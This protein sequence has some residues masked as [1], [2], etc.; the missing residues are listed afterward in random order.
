MVPSDRFEGH[1]SG[2]APEYEA[3]LADA[4]GL[5]L[6]VVFDTLGPTER[7]AVVLHD[8]FAMPFG[9]LAPIVGRSSTAARQ[10]ASRARRRVQRATTDADADRTGQRAV[11]DAFL[12]AS[13]VGDFET[14]VALLDPDVVLRADRT[15]VQT[16]ASAEVRGAL[17]VAGQFSGRARDAQPALVNGAAGAMWAPG[18]TPRV[19]F[20]FTVVQGKIVAI[21]MIAD[22]GRRQA[23]DL[24]ILDDWRW[25][26]R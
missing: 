16:G 2:T 10:L 6:L 9:E 18:G 11:A 19:I 17:A 25:T 21:A 8:L 24:A 23:V 14:L 22:A 15:T 26:R 5:A 4:V 7:L 20:D 12:A 1:T 13:H 3:L